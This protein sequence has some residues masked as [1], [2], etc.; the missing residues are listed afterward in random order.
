MYRYIIDYIEVLFLIYIEIET[1]LFECQP[2]V[3]ERLA[4]KASVDSFIF[5]V[6]FERLLQPRKERACLVRYSVKKTRGKEM[7]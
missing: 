1:D 2:N 7:H 4:E 5:F 6:F 3:F